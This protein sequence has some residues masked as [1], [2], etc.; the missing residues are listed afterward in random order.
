MR[1]VRI[2]YRV[3]L[4]RV[5]TRQLDSVQSTKT[6]GNNTKIFPVL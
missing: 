2:L 6:I 4:P 3:D 5:T 1:L